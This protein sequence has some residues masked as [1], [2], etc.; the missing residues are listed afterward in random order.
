MRVDA[1]DR[2]GPAGSNLCEI[3]WHD[4]MIGAASV[5]VSSY[6]HYMDKSAQYNRVCWHSRR[7]MLE[8]DL[9][10]GPFVEHC[11]P[12]L[13]A[14]DQHRYQLLLECEDQDLFSFFLGRVTPQDEELASIVS[15][16][17]DYTRRPL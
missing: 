12:D 3:V 2:Q 8:L 4:G 6:N 7:G 14:V 1:T 17:L 10:L 13:P 11:Y 9:V 15:T 5:L 16:I